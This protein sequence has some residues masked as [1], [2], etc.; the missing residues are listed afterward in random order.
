MF[1]W[2]FQFVLILALSIWVG[3]IVFFSAVVAPGIFGNL[4]RGQ[5]GK[6]LSHLFPRYYLVGT[7]CGA[8][9][10]GV[11]VLLF[12]FDS[13][14]RGMRLI[15]LLLAGLMLAGNLYAAGVLE[16]Q[17]H[18]L[19]EERVTAMGPAAREEAGRRFDALHRRSVNLNLAVL[20]LGVSA[21]GTAAV[22]RKSPA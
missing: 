8:V 15:Q 3:A 1:R 2:L 11:L 6:L 12:V 5:A 16:P 10:V 9:A 19:R 7:L 18:Q 4:E 13:G 21:L 22:R 14:F 20:G 17:V